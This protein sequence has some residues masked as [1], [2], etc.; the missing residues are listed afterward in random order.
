MADT[1]YESER[2]EEVTTPEIPAENETPVE[3]TSADT[4]PVEAPTAEVVDEQEPKNDLRLNGIHLALGICDALLTSVERETFHGGIR[5][6]N[7]RIQDNTVKLGGRLKHEVG[8]FT[9][10]ELEYM[11]PEL[12]WDGLRTPSADVYSVGLILYS[13]YNY[14]R[15]PFWPRVGAITPNGRASA[16]QKR[17]NGMDIPAP[18]AADPDLAAVIARAL[19][20]STDERWEDIVELRDALGQCDVSDGPADISMV[21]DGLVSRGGNSNPLSDEASRKAVQKAAEEAVDHENADDEADFAGRRYRRRRNLS[22]I[23]IGVLLA[24]IVGSL[25]LL[26]GNC[27]G[28]NAPPQDELPGTLVGNH[29]DTIP[30]P[31]PSPS[32]TPGPTATPEPTE[33]P[34]GP[35]YVV[36]IED[37]SW[38]EAVAR[39]A[40]LGG[41]LAMPTN[42]EELKA[43]TDALELAGLDNAWLG[44]SRQTDG[45]WA[46]PEGDVVSYYFWGNGEPSFHDSGD[47]VREDFM[48]LWLFNGVW[49]GNDSR[50]DPLEDYFWSYTGKI[51]FVCQM[52]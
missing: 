5:P 49:S 26:L 34:A 19:A 17:M 52:Y 12:F 41:R 43:I 6:D 27:G 18:A 50:E 28:K 33:E 51:G 45:T 8:E 48:L 39:C 4:P 46:T 40:E 38:G 29:A 15:L 20:F 31:S 14:G 2:T 3:E 7:I 21:M 11:A 36:Y 10:Q 47:G 16:L 13:V 37:V 44:A 1:T 22:W 24:F 23:W 30:T 42:D 35:Q 9:P 25:I 32:P